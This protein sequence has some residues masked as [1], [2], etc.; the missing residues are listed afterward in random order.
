M[1]LPE[2]VLSPIVSVAWPD[3]SPLLSIPP[4]LPAELP[5]TVL[6]RIVSVAVP[7]FASL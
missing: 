1:E 5:E 6:L 2:I 4:P 7:P 3:D